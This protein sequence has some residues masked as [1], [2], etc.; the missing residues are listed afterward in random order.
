M[1]DTKIAIVIRE[2][3]AVWQKLNVTAF[4]TSGIVGAHDGIIGEVYED[5]AGNRYNPLIV[6]PMM[7]YAAPAEKMATVYRRAMDRGAQ[8]SI[9]IKEMFAT[10]DDT[11]NRA[12]VKA[13]DPE[14]M[15]IVGLAFREDRKAVDKITKG[16]KLHG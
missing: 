13:A 9:Y 7:I 12:A 10:G 1:F 2:D 8:I 14:T 5:A 4:L 6:Q 16:L 15:S 11:A 3:L